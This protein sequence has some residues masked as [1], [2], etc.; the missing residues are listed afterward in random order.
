MHDSGICRLRQDIHVG[1][2]RLNNLRKCGSEL[3]IELCMLL[4]SIVCRIYQLSANLLEP[5]IR[6]NIQ[7]LAMPMDRGTKKSMLFENAA[8]GY[9][10]AYENQVHHGEILIQ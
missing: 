7:S 10:S 5:I 2:I 8:L 4:Q 1:H 6:K 9:H 3:L